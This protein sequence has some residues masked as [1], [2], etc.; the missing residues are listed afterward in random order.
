[1]REINTG[2]MKCREAILKCIQRDTRANQGNYN[3]K[4][5][6]AV[7]VC[8]REKWGREREREREGY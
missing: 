6:A 7:R 8:R 4:R 5:I 3:R 1:M 2:L